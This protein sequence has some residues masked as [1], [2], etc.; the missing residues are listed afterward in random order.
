MKDRKGLG[1]G[2]AS[3]LPEAKKS[4]GAMADRVVLCDVQSIQPNKRQPRKKYKKESLKELSESIMEKGIIQPLIVR[5]SG[6][7][8]NLIAGH[9]RLEAAKMAGIDQV[10]VI[11]KETTDSED[12]EL[13]LIE[14]IQR[15]DLNPID[16]ANGYKMLIEEFDIS[17]EEVAKRVSKGRAT[18]TNFL[19]LLKLPQKIQ[20]ALLEGKIS[21]G[22]ARTILALDSENEQLTF[23]DQILKANL[24]V[25]KSEEV[26]KRIKKG[27]KSFKLDSKAQN[28]FLRSIIEELQQVLGTRVKIIQKNNSKGTIQIEFFSTKDLNRILAAIRK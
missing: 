2:F 21:M 16:E 28:P 1:K 11:L 19:R 13:A 18:I 25:R 5:R 15:E 6:N 26:V 4:F 3:L 24:S 27:S 17:H 9:R 23:L 22:H 8:Y 20:D 12:L 10:P 7:A 14:N